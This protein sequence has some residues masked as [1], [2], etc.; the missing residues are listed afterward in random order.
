MGRRLDQLNGKLAPVDDEVAAQ[1]TKPPARDRDQ[2]V[3]CGESGPYVS[4][5]PV[6]DFPTVPGDSAR[7]DQQ[8]VWG[9]RWTLVRTLPCRSLGHL[10]GSGTDVLHARFL[11]KSASFPSVP[12]ACT[13][14]LWV[15]G[16][17][18]SIERR[19]HPLR[20][21]CCGRHSTPVRPARRLLVGR[22][23]RAVYNPLFST[24]PSSRSQPSGAAASRQRVGLRIPIETNKGEDGHG[25]LS[26]PSKN[27]KSPMKRRRFAFPGSQCGC[28]SFRYLNPSFSSLH[29]SIDR[30][31]SRSGGFRERHSR[32]M[33]VRHPI[34]SSL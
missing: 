5:G 1:R 22:D 29:H 16:S 2:T 12:P 10:D 4:P 28:A 7:S 27:P 34:L 24:L 3:A 31:D 11:H 18:K 33:S 19:A 23:L 30:S 17:E 21:C 6:Q 26:P 25:R 8:S 13:A 14:P 20:H 32:G 9:D 15:P